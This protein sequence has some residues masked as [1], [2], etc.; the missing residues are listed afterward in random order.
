MI[1]IDEKFRGEINEVD[2]PE[3]IKALKDITLGIQAS[4]FTMII[5]DIGSGKSSFLFSILNEMKASKSAF[6]EVNGSLAYVPQKPWIMSGTVRDNI[7]FTMP[8][9]KQ[10]FNEVIKHASMTTDLGL[11]VNRDLT[12]IG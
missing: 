5:G 1:S 7:T 10:K 2:K 6:V 8:F 9:D 3:F 11:L 12:E 4:S